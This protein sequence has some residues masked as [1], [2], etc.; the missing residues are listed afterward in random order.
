[1]EASNEYII[2]VNIHE[3]NTKNDLYHETLKCLCGVGES[4]W[5]LDEFEQSEGSGDGSVRNVFEGFRNLVVGSN[6]IKLR[7]NDRALLGRR[8]VM[9]VWDWIPV[10]DR[11]IFQGTVVSAGSPITGVFFGIMQRGED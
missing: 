3:R 5:H 9:D 2:D 4:K 10:R 8:K 11:L 6:K 1:M 7:E